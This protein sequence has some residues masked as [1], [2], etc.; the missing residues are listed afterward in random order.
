MRGYSRL[1]FYAKLLALAGLGVLGT[2]GVLIDHWPTSVD[3]PAVPSLS[4]RQTSPSVHT[5]FDVP[6]LGA[7]GVERVTLSRSVARKPPVAVTEVQVA[8]SQP[9]LEPDPVDDVQ[10][11]LPV[12][13]GVA[14]FRAPAF[15]LQDELLVD[16]ADTWQPMSA[17]AMAAADQSDNGFFSG[18]LKKTGSSVSTSLSKAGTSL[19]GAVRSVGGVVKKVF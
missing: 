9:A 17:P 15:D 10:D 3:L 12:A 7:P 19:L 1:D 2:M 4:A 18:M 13:V 6:G 8:E 16:E 5:A 11:T 14:A